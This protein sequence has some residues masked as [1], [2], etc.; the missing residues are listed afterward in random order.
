MV[1]RRATRAVTPPTAQVLS[2]EQIL[3][4]ALSLI[5]REGVEKLSMRTLAARLRVTPMAIYYYVPHKEALLDLVVDAVY[6]LIPTPAPDPTRWQAQMKAYALA[7][8]QLLDAYPG[9]SR[10][11]I[12]RPD[13]KAAHAIARYG[14]DLLLSAGFATREAALALATYQAYLFGVYSAQRPLAPSTP[15]K[16]QPARRKSVKLAAVEADRTD[17]V[18]REL[19]ELRMEDMLDYGIDAIIEGI[20]AHTKRMRARVTGAKR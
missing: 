4:T 14:I 1:S 20:A 2:E 11:I 15:T 19:R 10:V 6:S 13:S 16:Q 17:A 9:L 5:R 7:A 12:E 8:K 18:A 3:E